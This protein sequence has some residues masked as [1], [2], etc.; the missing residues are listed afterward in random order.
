MRQA[1]SRYRQDKGF[2]GSLVLCYTFESRGVAVCTFFSSLTT[3]CCIC[4]YNGSSSVYCSSL[5][6]AVLSALGLAIKAVTAFITS[7]GRPGSFAC[8]LLPALSSLAQNMAV[9][10]ASCCE[11]AARE[12]RW[13]I[14]PLATGQLDPAESEEVSQSCLT[15]GVTQTILEGGRSSNLKASWTPGGQ[16]PVL[17]KSAYG[18]NHAPPRML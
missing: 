12:A 3:A 14:M 13:S 2:G 5:P 6:S 17:Q 4:V 10:P 7:S 1:D 11:Q 8:R 9:K 18:L 15:V 16:V